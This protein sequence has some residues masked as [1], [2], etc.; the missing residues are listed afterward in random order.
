MQ[1]SN[2]RIG[3]NTGLL[4][5]CQPEDPS[6]DTF[7][8]WN[9]KRAFGQSIAKRIANNEP[10]QSS[11][12]KAGG[13]SKKRTRDTMQLDG[14]AD[15]PEG[16]T[17]E[18]EQEGFEAESAAESKLPAPEK[19]YQ[20]GCTYLHKGVM[21]NISLGWPYEDICAELIRLLEAKEGTCQAHNFEMAETWDLCQGH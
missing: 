3:T 10:G 17:V 21:K 11:M 8:Q 5:K 13:G 12:R 14:V 19:N 1:K 7:K 6:D 9:D 20:S 16:D 18:E 4:H 15:E 2:Y